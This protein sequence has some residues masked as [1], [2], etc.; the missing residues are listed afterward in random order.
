[1]SEYKKFIQF[2]K[3]LY[4]TNEGIP[5]HA[6]QFLGNEISYVTNAIK[7]TFVSSVGSYVDDF[8]SQMKQY[9]QANGAI[10]V[11]NGTSALHLCLYM[12]GVEADDLVI[13]QALTFV[14]T[15]NAINQIGA[16]PILLD[17]SIDSLSLC[18]IALEDFLESSAILDERGCIHRLTQ[19]R[20][21]AIL[22]MHT[23]GHPAKLDEIN[24]VCKKW[25]I[26]LV[27]DAAESLG[28][29][30]KGKHTGTIG[31]FAALSFNGNKI[32]T[33]GGGGMVLCQDEKDAV[34][35]KHLST[36]AKVAHPYEF[37]HDESGFN[38][39]MPNLNAALGCGQLESLPK[40]LENK[41]KL[42][43]IY[44]SFFKDSDCK[45]VIEPEYAESNYWLNA[46]VCPDKIYR[47]NFLKQT[48]LQGITTRPVWTLM[49]NLPMFKESIQ[50]S[51]VISKK[52]EQTLINIPSS[53]IFGLDE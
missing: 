37:Y 32:I 24:Q 14:A 17:V 30:Y 20:I 48:N 27:E 51:L 1:M 16:S 41:K 44:N 26:K 46:I 50:D 39:R 7:S 38:Y 31:D 36:T 25:N 42:A 21:R 29:K 15:C 12:A 9:T 35:I 53:P 4:G 52:L 47:D 23:F 49:S 19:R 22:P 28:S 33:T 18:P 10:A 2:E 13:T 3:D 11:V 45:F 8:E 5:L 34:R 43:S 40:Y 6:P